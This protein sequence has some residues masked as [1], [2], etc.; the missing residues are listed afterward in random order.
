M[1][2]IDS[3]KNLVKYF[4]KNLTKGYT[5][6][7]LRM[8]LMKQGYPRIVVDNALEQA[9]KD[10]AEKAPVLKEKPKITYQIIDEND[11]PI[12]IKKSWWKKLFK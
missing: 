10:L 3:R 5:P 11:N 2:R 12:E 6:D 7:A 4:K 9:N 1:S 8:A